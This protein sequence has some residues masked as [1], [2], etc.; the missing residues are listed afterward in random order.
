VRQLLVIALFVVGCDAG[1]GPPPTDSCATPSAG[2]A[3]TLEVGAA[4]SADLTGMP[5][6]FAP[7]SDG[8][9]MALIRGPQGANMIG[10]VL[11]VSGSAA[12]ACLGQQTTVTDTGGARI[13]AASPPLATYA[14]PDGTRLTHPLWLP[15]DYPATF[16]VSVAAGGQAVTLHLH[17][18]LAK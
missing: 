9:G 1:A 11:R 17:L 15:A 7:L 18:L 13:T 5:T 6:A 12:P 16:V 4:S 14:Q 3:D 2:S 10:L 8:D